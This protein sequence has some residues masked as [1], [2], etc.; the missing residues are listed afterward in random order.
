MKQIILTLGLLLA[1]LGNL[2]PAI[3]ASTNWQELGGGKARIIAVKD[4]ETDR[5]EGMVEIQLD[6]GWKT[7]WRSPGNS[8][9]APVFDFVGSNFVDIDRVG[10]PVPEV[11]EI[12][13]SFFMGYHDNVR[14]V[15]SGMTFSTD[16]ELSMNLFIGVCEEICIPATAE[17]K[18]DAASLNTSD[19]KG[20]SE[21]SLAKSMIP[22]LPNPEFQIVSAGPSATGISVTTVVPKQTD[23]TILLVEGPNG[24][25][26]GPV[27]PEKK[28]NNFAVKMPAGYSEKK[29]WANNYRYTLIADGRA[30]EGFLDTIPTQ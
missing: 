2:S 4:P 3:A 30:V 27:R 6:K 19:P 11:I 9:I 12:P 21:L 13:D 22:E 15:F 29:A 5:I 10:Y 28:Q 14:F 1:S 16:A 24:W 23:S 8:G 20:L 18:I 25:F 17:F 26:S 7:Y